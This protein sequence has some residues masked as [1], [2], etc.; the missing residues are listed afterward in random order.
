MPGRDPTGTCPPDH[1]QPARALRAATGGPPKG[2]APPQ[3][4]IQGPSSRP[5][6]NAM[7]PSHGCRPSRKRSCIHPSIPFLHPQMSSIPPPPPTPVPPLFS[8]S[9]LPFLSPNNTPP[10]S[11][12]CNH[13]DPLSLNV[14]Q[15]RTPPLQT[16]RRGH[17]CHLPVA[18][19]AAAAAAAATAAAAAQLESPGPARLPDRNTSQP[20][21]AGRGLT[22]LGLPVPTPLAA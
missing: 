20:I 17:R 15:P 21:T 16:V 8:F 13:L 3:G 2:L 19:A 9:A 5:R 7:P 14:P 22:V 4:T 1:L 11:S 18:F 12:P 10:H 6:P